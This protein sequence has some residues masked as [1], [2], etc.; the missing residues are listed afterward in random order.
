MSVTRPWVG[1]ID[2]RISTVTAVDTV[3]EVTTIGGIT[4]TVNVSDMNARDLQIET[5]TTLKK[6]E[7]HL[8][9]MTGVDLEHTN[10]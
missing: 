8:S 9:L 7:Y 3:G 6:I 2:G 5:L 4:D 10:L 1:I